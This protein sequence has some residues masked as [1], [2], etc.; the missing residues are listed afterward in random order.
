MRGTVAK[1][2]RKE[3]YGDFSTRERTYR[4]KWYEKILKSKNKDE[5]DRKVRTGTIRDF[6]LRAKYQAAKRAYYLNGATIG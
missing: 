4:V 2:I 6:G 3:V 5:E 1:R